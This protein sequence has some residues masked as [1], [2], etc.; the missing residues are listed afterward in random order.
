MWYVSQI[1][2]NNQM[3]FPKA[4]SF[5]I[6]GKN[7]KSWLKKMQKER[8]KI[9]ESVF[10]RK[11]FHRGWIIFGKKMIF[12]I[13]S[14]L[15]FP[16]KVKK[17]YN[18]TNTY[19]RATNW[20]SYMAK[21]KNQILKKRIRDFWF[22]ILPEQVRI[23]KLISW[24]RRSKGDFYQAEAGKENTWISTKWVK[25]TSLIKWTK[26]K[27]NQEMGS[28]EKVTNLWARGPRLQTT[29]L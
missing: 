7:R 21:C 24:N 23:H 27:R 11:W 16:K 13:F 10:S 6:F 8:H 15:L 25:T 19:L 22:L 20:R 9:A 17:N 2:I 18:V 5:H 1:K 4:K 26:K 3:K 12:T 14:S 29:W 28:K